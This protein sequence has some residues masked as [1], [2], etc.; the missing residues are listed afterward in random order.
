VLETAASLANAPLI[1]SA[2]G[3]VGGGGSRLT[4]TALALLDAWRQLQ[5]NHAGFL[6]EQEQWLLQQPAL[7]GVLRRMAM[8]TT[9]RNQFYGTIS[10]LELGPV[11]AEVV[12]TLPG[13]Q[14]IR[15]R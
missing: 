6:R 9:A 15:R 4:P 8:K 7:A 5:R 3:G 13:G 12:I 11:S 2:V 10:G 14:E 1:E